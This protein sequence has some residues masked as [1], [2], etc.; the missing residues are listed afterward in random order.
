M[1]AHKLRNYIPTK[2]TEKCNSFKMSEKD[3]LGNAVHFDEAKSQD[4]S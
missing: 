1:T 4:T 2:L 3:N